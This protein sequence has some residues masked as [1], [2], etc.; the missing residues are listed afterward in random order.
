MGWLWIRLTES[1]QQ[2][3]LA[4]RDSHRSACVLRR[5]QFLWSLHCGL[6]RETAARVFG[7]ATSS[8]ARDVRHCRWP[9]TFP[10]IDGLVG[11]HT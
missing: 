6:K 2:R 7:M 11:V 8:V 5:L 1:E 3:V 10:S 9:R 4:E